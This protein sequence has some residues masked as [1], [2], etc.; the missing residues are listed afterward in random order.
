M[1]NT[2]ARSSS[3]CVHTLLALCLASIFCVL[4]AFAEEA[5]EPVPD[6]EPGKLRHD[7]NGAEQMCGGPG[8]Q[9]IENNQ[10]LQI[11]YGQSAAKPVLIFKHST[12][13][14][15]SARA[16][17]RVHR[18]AES[19]SDRPDIYWLKVIE[20]R[21]A[22]NMLERLTGVKH[23]SPQILL[24]DHGEAVWNTSHDDVTAEAIEAAVV[25]LTASELDASDSDDEAPLD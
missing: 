24:I 15:I 3:F 5:E 12:Q 25:R 4:T 10:Q 22:S 16:A 11:V 7:K 8:L 14:P 2:P 1:K 19:T 13:C 6:D 20:S 17:A 18:Y 21:S 9:E 23:E